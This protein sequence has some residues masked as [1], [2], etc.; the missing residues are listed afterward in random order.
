MTSNILSPIQVFHDDPDAPWVV[1]HTQEIS[2]DFLEHAKALRE[3]S[4]APAGDY[5]QIAS[6]PTIVVEQWM[7]EGFNIFDQNVDAREIVKR[8]RAENLDAFLTT[9]K[10]I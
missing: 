1:E 4:S 8:L 2:D 3:A 5:H 10:R 9:N 7:R 6:I